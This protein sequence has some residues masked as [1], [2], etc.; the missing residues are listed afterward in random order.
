MTGAHE[1]RVESHE[2]QG[3]LFDGLD[4]FANRDQKWLVEVEFAKGEFG[5]VRGILKERMALVGLFK[6]DLDE[7]HFGLAEELKMTLG[8]RPAIG[9]FARAY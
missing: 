4:Q 3:D 8:G 5:P 7:I 9:A 6:L 1:R 2:D